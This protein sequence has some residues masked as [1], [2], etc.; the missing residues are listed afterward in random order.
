MH[1]VDPGYLGY[2]SRQEV[3]VF[4]KSLLEQERGGT[5]AFANIGQAANLKIADLILGSELDQG[6][7]CVLLQNEIAMRGAAVAVPRKRPANEHRTKCSLEHAI[8]SAT[9]NQAELVQTIEQAVP[10]IFDP[11]LNSHLTKMLQLHRKQVE[12]LK[13]LLT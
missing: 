1:E 7:I 8:A 2:W 11:E 3:L 10:N 13:T 6:E 5:K 12:Q 9:A 4:L